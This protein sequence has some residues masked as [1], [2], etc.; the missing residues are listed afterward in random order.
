MKERETPKRF[1]SYLSPNL[2]VNI[3]QAIYA[4]VV[5][6]LYHYLIPATSLYHNYFYFRKLCMTSGR[7][8]DSPAKTWA[9]FLGDISY[10]SFE[11]HLH[12]QMEQSK[13]LHSN[14]NITQQ[15]PVVWLVGVQ[16]KIQHF[17]FDFYENLLC[18]QGER[19]HLIAS[20]CHFLLG[21][22]FPQVRLEFP[23]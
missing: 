4:G 7:P 8:Q 3:T 16:P 6:T 22:K 13:R 15:Q 9:Q 20:M 2:V 11:F 17:L 21:G 18:S 10:A 14:G 1:V 19:K 23:T 12:Q 5:M